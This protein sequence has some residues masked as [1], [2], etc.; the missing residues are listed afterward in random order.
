LKASSQARYFAT[1]VK[2]QKKRISFK[3]HH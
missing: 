2:I 1:S 3:P